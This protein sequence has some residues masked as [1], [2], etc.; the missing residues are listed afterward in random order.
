MRKLA[1]LG[2]ATAVLVAAPAGSQVWIGMM[3]GNYHPPQPGVTAKCYDGRWQPAPDAVSMGPQRVEAAMHDYLTLAATGAD[4]LPMFTDKFRVLTVDG[5]DF[6]FP[7]AKDPWA[8]RVAR[9]ERT[10]FQVGNH[11]QGM[12]RALWRAVASDGTVLGIY[13]AALTQMPKGTKL[14]KLALY[15]AGSTKKPEPLGPFCVTQGDIEKWRAAQAKRKADEAAAR[16][17]RVVD[18][19]TR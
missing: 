9:L 17:A 11:K 3:V 10:G 12:Y 6:N 7:D 14:M 16:A 19:A 18:P 5:K 8:A 4:L 1:L 13:D 2:V 15:S